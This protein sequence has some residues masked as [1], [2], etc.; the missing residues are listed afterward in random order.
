[1]RN[2]RYMNRIHTPTG[3]PDAALWLKT[4]NTV[5]TTRPKEY[6]D[7]VCTKHQYRS[8]IINSLSNITSLFRYKRSYRT[9]CLLILK[10]EL[11]LCPVYILYNVLMDSIWM[12]YSFNASKR[13]CQM[14]SECGYFDYFSPL[15]ET[16]R[17]Y[18]TLSWFTARCRHR[19]P[20]DLPRLVAKLK[21][22][23]FKF[24]SKIN[25]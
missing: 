13:W 23:K 4:R 19:S 2:Y 15:C 18:H 5:V 11:T 14:R 10:Q 24:C 22:C 1:M 9:L 6:A 21:Y 17:F 25:K 16:G 7:F 12:Y 3:T 8:H 20:P